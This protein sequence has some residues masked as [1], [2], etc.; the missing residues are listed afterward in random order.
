MTNQI[1][2]YW[3]NRQTEQANLNYLKVFDNLED[4]HTKYM[5]LAEKHINKETDE[6]HII[7]DGLL[8]VDDMRKQLFHLTN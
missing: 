8:P 1:I 3:L 2:V 6:L 5:E 4:A 7:S